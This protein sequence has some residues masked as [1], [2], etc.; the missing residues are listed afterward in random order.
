MLTV[1][2]I[3][4]ISLS[5]SEF[6]RADKLFQKSHV[7]F[8]KSLAVL[9][10]LIFISSICSASTSFNKNQATGFTENKGQIIDQN[11]KPNPDVLFLFNST[12]MNVQLRRGG[13]SYDVYANEEKEDKDSINLSRELK[14]LEDLKRINK[15]TTRYFHRIDIDLAGANIN[16]GVVAEE[17]SEAYFNYYNIEKPVLNVHKYNRV[18][19]TDIYPGIDLV[20]TVGNGKPFEYTFVV[21]S[22]ASIAD[23]RLHVSGANSLKVNDD[24]VSYATTLSTIN[25]TIPRCWY[26]DDSKEYPVD[27]MFKQD[28]HN[29][30]GFESKD[31]IPKNVLVYI[32]PFPSRV[33][34]TYFGGEGGENRNTLFSRDSDS[35]YNTEYTVLAG[36]TNSSNMIATNGAFMTSIVSGF[37][38]G[39]ITKFSPDGHQLWGTYTDGTISSYTQDIFGNIVIGGS[40]ASDFTMTTPGAYQTI[41]YGMDGFIARFSSDGFLLW[42]TLYGG[43]NGPSL[44]EAESIT[45]LATDNYGDIY[46]QGITNI[47]NGIVSPG[48]Y[49][50]T[51][52]GGILDTYIVKFRYTGQREWATYYGGNGDDYTSKITVTGQGLIY[53]GGYTTSNTGIASGNSF[54]SI[55]KGPISNGFLACFSSSGTFNW[56]TYL[57]EIVTTCQVDLSDNV[58]VTGYNDLYNNIG[59]PGTYISSASFSNRMFLAKFDNAGNRIW[60][61]YL[62]IQIKCIYIKSNSEILVAGTGIYHPIAVSPG[63]YQSS[64][65]GL[66]DAYLGRFNNNGQFLWGSYYGGSSTDEGTYCYSTP[67]GE[68]YLGGIT[69]SP[70]RSTDQKCINGYNNNVIATQGAHSHELQG[71]EDRF[72]VKFTPCQ[73]PDTAN[74]INGPQRICTNTTGH[75]FSIDSIP[76]ADTIIWC[77]TGGLSITSGQGTNSITVSTGTIAA[78]DT[79][80]V[81]GRNDCGDGYSIFIV[82]S[83]VTAQTPTIKGADTICCFRTENYNTEVGMT[84]YYWL[85][86]SGGTIVSGGTSQDQSCEIKW[87]SSGNQWISVA[88]DD[89][90]G[91]IPADT[92]LINVFVE[93]SHPV[94]ITIAQQGTICEGNEAVFMAQIVNGGSKPILNWFVNGNNVFSGNT[95]FSYSPVQGDVIT[96]QLIT[97][98]TTCLENNPAISNSLIVDINPIPPPNPIK[99]N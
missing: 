43:S 18:T 84:N 83:T 1:Y 44:G 34:G 56:S 9:L 78:I 29:T 37:S 87:N 71:G 93:E 47:K 22:G 35:K 5:Q 90:E 15:T 12:G 38:S 53:I 99:H 58:Y 55:Y 52:A 26:V 50:S 75:I 3:S 28:G 11:N 21:K 59:T 49:Q 86:S 74:E 95:N 30:F 69:K 10:L 24:V 79:I 16:H 36:Q 65:R 94:S 33:W 8:S 62:P 72:I 14:T 77:A 88:Y 92:T 7:L 17:R 45:S 19:Y 31:R 54:N 73:T 41:V 57:G 80:A 85:I 68:I 42:C 48:A 82:V 60:G 96:C 97:S 64:V 81:R 63:T 39:F 32:D 98:L 2:W 25:E 46:A 61:T 20:F 40:A 23:I 76:Y 91:C 27:F 67:D 66:Y 89:P 70:N 6:P 51:Y 13:F 4:Y